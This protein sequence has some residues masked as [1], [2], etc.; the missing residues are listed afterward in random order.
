[1]LRTYML[2]RLVNGTNEAADGRK[3]WEIAAVVHH[4]M[5]WRESVLVAHLHSDVETRVACGARRASEM[6]EA[7]D[8]ERLGR[9]RA[10]LEKFLGLIDHKATYV[11][12]TH[13][14][15]QKLFASSAASGPDCRRKGAFAVPP[16][17][18]DRHTSTY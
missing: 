4:V 17:T 11:F 8:P 15:C 9:L 16:G 13:M 14:Q 7:A 5:Y 10:A 12:A 1:M 3:A 18:Q 2:S 6:A